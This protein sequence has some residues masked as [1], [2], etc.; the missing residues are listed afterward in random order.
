MPPLNFQFM[1]ESHNDSEVRFVE[2]WSRLW[3]EH[4]GP[5]WPDLF[6]E[7]AVLRNPMGEVGRAD[8][9]G[10]MEAL[11]ALAPDHRLAA[12]R[13]GTTPDDVLIEWVM[14]G[15]LPGGPVEIHGA[16]RFTLRDG[17]ATEG[18][19][20]FD[21]RPW[22]ER[23]TAPP[24]EPDRV[25]AIARTY[26]AA[27]NAHDLEAIVAAHA[28][29]GSFRLH[30]AGSPSVHGR[31]A[32]RRAFAASLA[33]WRE[34]SFALERV[35]RGDRFYVWEST[36]RGT[37]ARPLQFGAV[38]VEP[39]SAPLA[40]TAVDVVTLDGDGLIR[41]KDTYVDIVAAANQAAAATP[42]VPGP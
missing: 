24:L 5:G 41:T 26:D 10:F 3:R 30:L 34:L 7:G 17:R 27:W 19:A 25:E 40:F 22:I 23:M 9:P 11:V 13:W 20:Y 31:D 2:G 1:V 12:S 14:T 16:D 15:T 4:D 35:Q 42:P 32:L 39:T 21:P 18:S 33:G 38:T 28:P 37:L 36:V 29:D 6:H 8:L